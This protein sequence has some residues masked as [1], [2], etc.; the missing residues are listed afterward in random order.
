MKSY[1]FV[2]AQS[3]ET[4]P[5]EYLRRRT[6]VCSTTTAPD[7]NETYSSVKHYFRFSQAAHKQRII[8]SV[9]LILYARAVRR[10]SLVR[11]HTHTLCIR[12]K[13]IINNFARIENKETTILVCMYMHYA[14]RK[15]ICKQ[16]QTQKKNANL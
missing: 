9:I 13:W 1:I 11:A 2:L 16:Q 10:R 14:N 15:T 5:A 3:R 8:Y 7:S 4:A 12:F 6:L